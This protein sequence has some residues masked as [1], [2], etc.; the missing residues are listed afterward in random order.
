M[1]RGQRG[2]EGLRPEKRQEARGLC[3]SGCGLTEMP[4]PKSLRSVGEEAFCGC[5]RLSRLCIEEG[6]AL[7]HVGYRAFARTRLSPEQLG[8]LAGLEEREPEK[9]EE[10]R[11]EED[12]E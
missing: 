6:S 5:A 12:W 10:D 8:F 4:I 1:V 2:G 9:A 7:E 3:F 11:E